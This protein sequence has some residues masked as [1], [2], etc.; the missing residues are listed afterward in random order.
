M[1][2]QPP[3][4]VRGRIVNMVAARHRRRAR[5]IA[6]GTSKSAIMYITRQ[7]ATEYADEG[8]IC[9]AV[10]PGK[11]FTGK[12][13]REHEPKWPE[14]WQ[15]RTPRP[16]RAVQEDVA[17]RRPLPRERRRDVHHRRNLMVDGGWSAS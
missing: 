1:L 15:A 10:A 7:I 2:T 9:N 16:R 12:G 8:I 6:Y 5:D 13:G 17:R 11:I 4:A 3:T 14:S